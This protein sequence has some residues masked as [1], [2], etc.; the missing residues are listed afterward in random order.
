MTGKKPVLNKSFPNV[1]PGPI[2]MEKILIP[3]SLI[4]FL[5]IMPVTLQ[6]QMFS[7]E[8]PERRIR[9]SSNSVTAGPE[10]LTMRLREGE[11]FSGRVYN[12]TEPVYRVRIELPGVEIY[13]GFRN[14]IGD[15]DSLNYLNLGANI[16][17]SLQLARS[18]SAGIL[19]PIWLTTD[20]TRVKETGNQQPENEQFRQSSAS[21]GLGAGAYVNPV[22]NIRVRAE[23]V[24]QIGFTLSSMGSDSGQ[25]ASLNGRL[26]FHVDQIFGRYGLVASYNYTWRRYSGTD[27]R[28]H[29]D[30]EGHHVGLGITF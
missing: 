22:R 29:Y 5:A 6:A 23:F 18:R 24:P 8:E 9:P 7:V 19:L 4:L 21:I 17:G 25:L 15:A 26:K 14:Q 2:K 3:V 16:S 13:G 11:S 30:L 27:D 12:F 20:Y 1:T 28:F 10:F